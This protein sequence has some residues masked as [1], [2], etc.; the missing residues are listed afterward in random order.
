MFNTTGD[1]RTGKVTVVLDAK[2]D[3]NKWLW[4]GRRDMKAWELPEYVVV[5]SE[6]NV[7]KATVEDADVKFGYDLPDDKFRQ[8]YMARQVKVS[9]FAEKLPALG[10]RTYA[11][12]PAEAAGTAVKGS[13]IASDDRHLENEFLKVAVNDDGTLNVLDKQ[14]G[15]DLRRSWIF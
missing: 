9:L 1:E 8:P 5:D 11:L 13:N 3:Y 10:Y 4:D 15:K 12:V 14:T 2:R 6:G 7:Q